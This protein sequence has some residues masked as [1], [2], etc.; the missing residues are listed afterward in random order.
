MLNIFEK[1]KSRKVEVTRK[2]DRD[3]SA[4]VQTLEDA[5]TP[6]DADKILAELERRGRTIED[7]EKAADLL[8][9]RWKWAKELADGEKAEVARNISIQE[10][11][12]EEAAFEKRQAEHQA[13]LSPLID[14]RQ[15][16]VESIHRAADAKRRLLD[17]ASETARS[18]AFGDIDAKMAELKVDHEPI[19]KAIHDRR[20]WISKVEERGEHAATL[21]M[22]RLSEAKKGL[23]VMLKQ[24][25]ELNNRLS[26]LQDERA[27]AMA[28][29]L[30]PEAI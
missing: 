2:Q 14:A 19:L 11:A 4:L 15:R 21:D 10:I 18:A 1:L 16:A 24:D 3:W 22:E 30:K 17:T 26:Q 29:L 6:E 20:N 5:K 13:R 23:A 27:A 8:I 25:S 12:A 28:K 9:Q 7:L